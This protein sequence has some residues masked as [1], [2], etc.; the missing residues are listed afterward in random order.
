[1]QYQGQ[2]KGKS[3]GNQGEIK[4]DSKDVLARGRAF[5]AAHLRRAKRGEERKKK[6]ARGGSASAV[7]R[8]TKR[9]DDRADPLIAPQNAGAV[10]FD[11]FGKRGVWQYQESAAGRW[12]RCKR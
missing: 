6:R 2:I 5:G 12:T 11:Q 4:E 10:Q 7:G 1:M 9:L 3:K 8:S